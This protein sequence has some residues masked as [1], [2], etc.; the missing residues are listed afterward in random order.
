MPN[1]GGHPQTI[2]PPPNPQRA[3][4]PGRAT[5]HG[6]FAERQIGE[7]AEAQALAVFDANE[8]LDRVRDRPAVLRYCVLLARLERVY[9]WLA[10]QPD[11]VF[12]DPEAGEA[13]RIFERVERWERAADT[14][15][16][17]L[18]LAPLARHRFGF[19]REPESDLATAFAELD[20][21]DPNG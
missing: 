2:Q 4:E 17:R 13:H 14:A 16:D 8:H 3:G 15:E 20:E 10:S 6:A 1:P 19:D 18:A 21:G 9:E 12:A 5:T 11:E 7:R